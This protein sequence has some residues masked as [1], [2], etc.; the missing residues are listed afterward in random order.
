MSEIPS[1][2]EFKR[3]TGCFADVITS[4]SQPFLFI[5]QVDTPDG[6]ARDAVYF[7][8]SRSQLMGLIELLDENVTLYLRSTTPDPYSSS[9]SVPGLDDENEEDE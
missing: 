6:V 9:N 1:T 4:K 8:G 7:R 3:L 2:P 5:S